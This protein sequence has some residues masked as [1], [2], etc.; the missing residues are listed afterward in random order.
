MHGWMP[1]TIPPAA[2]EAQSAT[3][4][5]PSF[6]TDDQAIAALLAAM[7]KNHHASAHGL[8]ERL[9]KAGFRVFRVR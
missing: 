6:L 2:P 8:H 3:E 9:A 5:A 4:A 1:P 7:A